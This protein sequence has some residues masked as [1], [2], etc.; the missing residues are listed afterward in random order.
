MQLGYR[1]RCLSLPDTPRA[2]LRLAGIHGPVYLLEHTSQSYPVGR[3]LTEAYADT[4][5]QVVFLGPCC[6][7]LLDPLGYGF[8]SIHADIL[9]HEHEFITAHSRRHIGGADRIPHYLRECA[10]HLVTHRMTMGVVDGLEFIEIGENQCQ[11][12]RMP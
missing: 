7:P 5:V 3:G 8:G 1:N 4:D 2:G 9:E 10:Q 11:P 6:H 12:R